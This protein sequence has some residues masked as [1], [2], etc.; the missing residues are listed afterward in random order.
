MRLDLA[1]VALCRRSQS[2]GPQNKTTQLI[3]CDDN[4][5]AFATEVERRESDHSRGARMSSLLG[6]EESCDNKRKEQQRI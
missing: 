3:G 2:Y 1:L 5:L 4:R 6:E